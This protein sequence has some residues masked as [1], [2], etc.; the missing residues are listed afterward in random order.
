MFL[1]LYSSF[2]TLRY[3]NANSW[4]VSEFCAPKLVTFKYFG[5]SKIRLSMG[6]LPLLSELD[7][8]ASQDHQ[9]TYALVPFSSY[10][11][12]IETSK[13][14]LSFVASISRFLPKKKVFQDL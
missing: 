14:A 7:V 12:Q 8:D 2:S 9:A 3:S 6:S 11:P 5:H 13:L 4:R 10:L 1:V